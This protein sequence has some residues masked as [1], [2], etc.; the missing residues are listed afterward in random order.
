MSNLEA[1]NIIPLNH[2]SCSTGDRGLDQHLREL[3]EEVRNLSKSSTASIIG[4]GK[5]L[6]EAKE[7]LKHGQFSKWVQIECGFTTR[8]GQNYMR[9][10]ELAR[11]NDIV[12]LLSPAAL[13]R[14]AA[15]KIPKHVVTRVIEMLQQGLVPTDAQLAAIILFLQNSVDTITTPESTGNGTLNFARELHARLGHELASRLIGSRWSDLRK[16]LRNII[17]APEEDSSSGTASSPAHIQ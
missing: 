15:P 1:A 5:A 2:P 3:A 10:A 16:H 8:T 7:H 6:L 9:A 12:A 13:Y 11:E 14:L 17:E 4:I